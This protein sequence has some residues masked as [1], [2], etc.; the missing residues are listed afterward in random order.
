MSKKVRAVAKGHEDIYEKILIRSPD[1]WKVAKIASICREK[2]K[3]PIKSYNDFLRLADKG[4]KSCRLGADV[5]TL[6]QVK[7]YFPKK[8][9]PIEDEDDLITKVLCSLLWGTRAHRME[10]ELKQAFSTGKKV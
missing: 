2:G 3:F 4:K 7:K 8:F 9:F 10:A 6:K 5:I 1:F